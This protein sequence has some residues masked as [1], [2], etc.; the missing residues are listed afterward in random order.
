M[1]PPQMTLASVP[2]E[3]RIGRQSISHHHS[4]KKVEHTDN[5]QCLILCQQGVIMGLGPT[6]WTHDH[7]VLWMTQK[8]HRAVVLLEM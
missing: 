2:S 1:R 6:P 3:V 7:L 4:Y 8:R 5:L